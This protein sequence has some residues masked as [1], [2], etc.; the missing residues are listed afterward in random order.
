[1]SKIHNNSIFSICYFSLLICEPEPTVFIFNI[2]PCILRVNV[3]TVLRLTRATAQNQC[4]WKRK[5]GKFRRKRVAARFRIDFHNQYRYLSGNMNQSNEITLSDQ[6][7]TIANRPTKGS[8]NGSGSK[9][10][11]FQIP[12]A[13]CTGFAP[14]QH[15]ACYGMFQ[16]CTNNGILGSKVT[17]VC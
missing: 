16:S 15:F 17:H 12:H 6:P 1:M 13:Y 5:W 11:A 3:R 7:I 2:N 9:I 8:G 14:R 4:R 10:C